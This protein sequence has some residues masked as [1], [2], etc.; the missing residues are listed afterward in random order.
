MECLLSCVLETL[1]TSGV[2]AVI[3]RIFTYS[4]ALWQ[5]FGELIFQRLE[6]WPA[7]VHLCIPSL[8]SHCFCLSHP[9]CGE[10]QFS[11]MFRRTE[12][13]KFVEW[14]SDPR[15]RRTNSDTKGPT[16]LVFA[17]QVWL[18]FEERKM[19]WKTKQGNSPD[20]LNRLWIFRNLPQCWKSNPRWM[21]EWGDSELF[22]GPYNQPREVVESLACGKGICATELC[23]F[24]TSPGIQLPWA[25]LMMDQKILKSKW[26]W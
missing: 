25:Y 2:A 14:T 23:P 15:S 19:V 21:L 10:K 7:F 4:C 13:C 24:T 12:E 5:Y 20:Y 17:S 18:Q 26:G 16:L 3:V 11:D 6:D 22:A 9:K 8:P 1:Q